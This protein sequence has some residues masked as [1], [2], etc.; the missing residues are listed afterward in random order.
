MLSES[1]PHPSY[2]SYRI[3]DLFSGMGSFH[4]AAREMG[5]A[6]TFAC[7][8]NPWTQLVYREN[9]GMHPS[10]DILNVDLAKV[11]AYDVLTAGFPCQPFSAMGKR[12]GIDN[13]A[14]GRG[15]MIYEVRK[16]LDA[17]RPPAFI[18][19]NV[20]GLVCSNQGQDMRR[21]LDLMEE[22][23]YAVSWTI[24]S[25]SD[26]GLPQARERVF[27]VGVRAEIAGEAGFRFPPPTPE[28]TPS[29]AELLGQPVKAGVR[30]K[31]IRASA[32]WRDKTKRAWDRLELEDGSTYLLTLKD[33]LLLQGYDADE[34]K[35][36]PLSERRRV[37]CLGNS[38]PTCLSRAVLGEVFAA[39]RRA[40]YEPSPERDAERHA[41]M[42]NTV[43]GGVDATTASNSGEVEPRTPMTTPTPPAPKRTKV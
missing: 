6:C 32:G 14:K 17:H 15:T 2:P 4:V 16:F 22:A 7:D 10:G 37:E 12:G 23:G 35:W 21:V 24:L 11:P 26:Y 8:K 30:S 19:E 28:I 1:P 36:P 18:L 13:D 42:K 41:T 25:A 34:W 27:I 33:C 5:G 31:T 40:G 43:D 9:H 39:L 20:K 38:I 29:L 3:A